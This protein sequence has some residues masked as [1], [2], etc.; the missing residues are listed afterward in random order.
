MALLSAAHGNLL[1]A[2]YV[3]AIHTGL[4]QSELLG[5]LLGLKWTDVDL[6]AGFLSFQRSLGTDGTFNSCKRNKI[7]RTVKLT[8]QAAEALNS[9]RA[10]QNEERLRLGSL[11][12]DHGL[13]FPNQLGKPMNADNLYPRGFRSLLEKAAPSGFTFLSLRH[14][15]ATLLLFKNLNPRRSSRK[16]WSKRRLPRRWTRILTSCRAW[17]TLPPRRPRRRSRNLLL[18]RAPAA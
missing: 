3:V 10:R 1:E 11:W 6:D 9:Q 17:G 15:C 18:P 13:G 14:T 16:C 8:G 2:I 12:E 7:R 5:Q 4:R